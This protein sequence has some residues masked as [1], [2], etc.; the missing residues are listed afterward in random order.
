MTEC[1]PCANRWHNIGL[2]LGLEDAELRNITE[3]S[4]DDCLREVL[5]LWLRHMMLEGKPLPSWY[6]LC[7][8]V[9]EAGKNPALAKEIADRHK[10][11]SDD[12]KI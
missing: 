12:G 10:R 2:S 5:S 11:V 1:K 3:S 6:A 9:H 4:V 7:V 8:A